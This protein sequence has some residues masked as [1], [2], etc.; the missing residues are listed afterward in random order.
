M[1]NK[2]VLQK[3]YKGDFFGQY[4]IYH[5][6]GTKHTLKAESKTVWISLRWEFANALLG[7]DI[8]SILNTNSIRHAIENSSV[9]NNLAEE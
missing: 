8:K 5:D 1:N 9:L 2:Q 7:G 4:S 6:E 3:L